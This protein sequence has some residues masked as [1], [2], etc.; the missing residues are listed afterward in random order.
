MEIIFS[1]YERFESL[2][3]P[4][5]TNTVNYMNELD[6]RYLKIK[7]RQMELTDGKLVQLLKFAISK[8]E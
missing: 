8:G 5:Y 6:R 3:R 7:V 1:Y 4:L 2:S